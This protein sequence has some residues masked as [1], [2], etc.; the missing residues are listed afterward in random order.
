ME[1]ILEVAAG[2]AF[3]VREIQRDVDIHVPEIFSFLHDL[4]E[5]AVILV[6]QG[7]LGFAGRRTGGGHE[8][9]GAV[10]V[11]LAQACEVFAD[12]SD[13]GFGWVAGVDIIAAALE[14]D[15]TRVV[16]QRD[17]IHVAEDLGR[18][19]ATEAAVDHRVGLHF[20]ADV[21]PHTQGAGAG[22]EQGMLRRRVGL[23]GGFEGGDVLGHAQ[24]LLG[25]GNVG[26]GDV[27][28]E[29]G[30]GEKAGEESFHIERGR[31]WGRGMKRQGGEE[32][33]KMEDRR[34]R[35][36]EAERCKGANAAVPRAKVQRWI[37]KT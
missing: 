15:H 16:R 9:Y 19:G 34:A 10:R 12:A 11:L 7:P 3:T 17:T 28:R 13:G 8:D 14:D 20:I 22:E 4:L 37:I 24:R 32:G 23:I 30:D 31:G 33:N 5:L 29:G 27:G 21:L 2:L 18:E 35:G 36:R 6:E 1:L 25:Q 26:L